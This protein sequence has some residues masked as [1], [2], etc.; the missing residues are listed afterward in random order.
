MFHNSTLA[1]I[2]ADIEKQ[3]SYN[4]SNGNK[5]NAKAAS[6]QSL[7]EKFQEW[8]FKVYTNELLVKFPQ[9][10][11]PDEV[12]KHF[13]ILFYCPDFEYLRHPKFWNTEESVLSPKQRS[14]NRSRRNSI[15]LVE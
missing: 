6:K 13:S 1:Y 11:S 14:R 10:I 8:E 7:R 2:Y 15:S 9:L 5:R 3:S 12:N 4:Q